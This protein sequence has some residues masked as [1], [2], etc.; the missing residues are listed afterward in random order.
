LFLQINKLSQPVQT[1]PSLRSVPVI[2]SLPSPSF[3]EEVAAI[4]QQQLKIRAADRDRQQAQ[5]AISAVLVKDDTWTINS[6][7]RVY[8]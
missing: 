5:R 2:A 6:K 3:L 7:T 1:P 4:Q 8:Q